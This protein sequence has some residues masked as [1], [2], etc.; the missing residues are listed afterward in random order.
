MKSICLWLSA[1]L[2][3]IS[4]AAF[5]QETART[6]WGD[7]DLQGTYTTDN[8]IGVPFQRPERY[9][10]SELL[11]EAEYAA[12]VDANDEQIE[13]DLAPEP[14]S[15]F[16][17]DDPASINAPRHWLER[18]EMPA[19]ANSLVVDPPNGRLPALTPEGERMQAERRRQLRNPP[20]SYTDFSIY[21]RC[22]T[23]GLTGSIIPVIYGNGTEIH[24]APGLVVIRNEMIHEARLIPLD[25]GPHAPAAI[26]MWMGDSRG[27]FEGDTLVVETT[28]FTDQ[29]GI[30]SNGGGAVHSED[31]RLVERFRRVAEDLIHYEFT[32]IDPA[33]YSA[34]WTARFELF[35]K[36]GYEIYEY[37]CHEGNLG[38]ANMLSAA[39][40]EERIANP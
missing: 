5:A 21:N 4:G 23:R 40:Y 27:R 9:G 6:P 13:K 15:E 16:S 32:V 3:S 28:N 36:P 30:G 39:R 26:K 20:Q 8:W 18:A 19:R 17:T 33:I 37:A 29:M 2:G 31:M 11:P 22:I 7:P 1:L 34:P 12:R 14:E 38:L 24:Q 10:E 25:G 35:A